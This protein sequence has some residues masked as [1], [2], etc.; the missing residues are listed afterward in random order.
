MDIKLKSKKGKIG[1]KL[2]LSYLTILIIAFLVVG[3]IFSFTLRNY[4]LRQAVRE[5]RNEGQKIAKALSNIP[6]N[7]TNINKR[8]K[9]MVELKIAGKYI[10]GKVLVLNKDKEII[11]PV[12]VD[13][14]LDNKFLLKLKRLENFKNKGYVIVRVPIINKISKVIGY[15]VLYTR[16]K[17]IN[18]L[19]KIIFNILLFSFSIA[20]TVALIISFVLEK[21]LVTP[22]AKLRDSMINFSIRNFNEDIV[23]KTNDEIQELAESFNI[24]A[25]KLR[26]YDESQ[27][28]F[29][30]NASHELKT[31]LM[32]IQGYAEAIKDGVIEGKELDEGLDIIIDE[33]QR[34]KKLVE[35]IIYLTKLEN[36]E[37]TFEFKEYSLKDIVEESIKSIKPLADERGIKIELKN[38]KDFKGYFDIEKMKRVF[39]NLLGNSIRYG[40]N[41][42]FIYMAEREDK[43][44][45]EVIDDGE[46]FKNNEES[47]I[48]D[49]FY[50][51]EDGGS[52]IGLAI[53]KAIVEVHRGKI[54]AYNHQNLGAVFKIELPK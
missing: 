9:A 34:L 25:H 30:Q 11:F 29:L 26:S 15:V 46:G 14:R 1:R 37:E 4:L 24:M 52:G 36:V 47:K 33:S 3:I 6:I 10:N 54:N 35:E 31:P 44:I 8:L 40:K 12:S 43:Y 42:I 51:G 32:S 22:I 17:E 5:L 2:I 49:R 39:I 16:V 7:K 28:R 50:K 38:G 18:E 41:K 19:N 23:V 27:K 48:F 20:M 21:G 13:K 45:I 53:T